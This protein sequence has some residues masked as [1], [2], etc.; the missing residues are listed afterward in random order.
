MTKDE[1]DKKASEVATMM[2]RHRLVTRLREAAR[3]LRPGAPGDFAR[4]AMLAAAFA[5]Y[6]L[7]TVPG[8]DGAALD[9]P[10]LMTVWERVT[11]HTALRRQELGWLEWGSEMIRSD[12]AD[13]LAQAEKLPQWTFNR[14]REGLFNVQC[15]ALSDLRNLIN[16]GAA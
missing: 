1:A 5:D 16:G 12:R 4:M 10:R 9:K 13:I 14:S 8:D 3:D 2:E 7:A 11:G 6:V 15:I